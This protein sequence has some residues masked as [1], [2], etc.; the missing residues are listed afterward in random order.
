MT[1]RATAAETYNATWTLLES[2]REGAQDL[3]LLTLALASRYHWAIAGDE[4]AKVIAD[5]MA[6]RCFAAAGEG[7]LAVR[8]ANASLAGLP[9]DAPPWLRAS[10]HEGLARAYANVGDADRRAVHL[11]QARGALE[12]ETDDEDRALVLGQIE[13]VP[14]VS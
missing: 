9:D 11:A 5:W 14:E 6:S 10:V 13:D 8:F 2:E 12:E 1:H 3:D 4:Q 7:S